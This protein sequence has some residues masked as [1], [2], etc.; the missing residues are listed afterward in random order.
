MPFRLF[1]LPPELVCTIVNLASRSSWPNN[2]PHNIR[3]AT[4]P[5]A[6]RLAR[7]CTTLYTLVMPLL[8]D[9]VILTS[10]RSTVAFL[11]A[12]SHHRAGRVSP[13]LRLNYPAL[14]RNLCL[15]DVPCEDSFPGCDVSTY[16]VQGIL[17]DMMCS[18]QSLCVSNLSL[19]ILI[20][21]FDPAKTRQ[22]SCRHLTLTGPFLRWNVFM[23]SP[24]GLAFLEQITHLAIWYPYHTESPPPAGQHPSPRF[25]ES[26]PAASMPNLRFI[27]FPLLNVKPY[28]EDSGRVAVLKLVYEDMLVM[29]GKDFKEAKLAGTLEEVRSV[30]VPLE[31]RPHKVRLPNWNIGYVQ[32][33][34]ERIW[35]LVGE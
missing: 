27:A 24:A 5:D 28:T 17:Y 31:H 19:P 8:L 3:P 15:D 35:K 29:Q 20:D 11:R 26:I 1:D 16:N 14:V 13:R 25:I 2:G 34:T 32:Q 30:Y 18:A 22:W 21:A 12:C 10:E 4:Y 23:R 9:T 33:E 6:A 7:V